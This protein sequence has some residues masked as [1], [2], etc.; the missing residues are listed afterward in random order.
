M[1]RDGDNYREWRGYL[2]RNAWTEYPIQH[3][4]NV[5]RYPLY[6]EPF[7]LHLQ[8]RLGLCFSHREVGFEEPEFEVLLP[9]Y[10]QESVYV[11]HLVYVKNVV[12]VM[13][14]QRLL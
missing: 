11:G 13:L 6:P 7:L 4:R 1:A 5:P 12:E 14:R 9:C 2:V 10:K 3:R 8:H